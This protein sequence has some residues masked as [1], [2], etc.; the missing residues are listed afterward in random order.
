MFSRSN[1]GALILTPV[2]FPGRD[3]PFRNVVRVLA[4]RRRWWHRSTTLEHH[5][6]AARRS[7]RVQTRA[8]KSPADYGPSCPTSFGGPHFA[9]RA[10]PSRSSKRRQLRIKTVLLS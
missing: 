1:D 8:L 7:F 4:H 6:Y 9:A 2:P 5:P 3:F 10:L